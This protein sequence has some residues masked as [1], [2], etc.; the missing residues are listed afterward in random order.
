MSTGKR[1]RFYGSSFEVQ[2]GFGS[3][4]TVTAITAADP[5]VVSAA[6]HGFT[7]GD[8]VKLANID[9]PTQLDDG[10]Y[11]VDNPLTGSFELAGVDGSAYDA[12]DAGSPNATATPVTFSEFC[13]LTGV[14][15]QDGSADQEEVSTICSTAKEFEQGLADSGTLQLDFNWAGNETVQAAL[16]AGRRS[17]DQLAFRVTMPGTG[18]SVIMIGTV[19]QTSFSGSTGQSVWKASATIKLSGDIFV[20]EAA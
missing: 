11:P 15:Q 14:N 3:A 17:G 6:A 10:V 7:L 8:V 18:G 19:Q 9:A 2:T 13:E 4:K 16:R 5:P 12:F 1:Y 20:L